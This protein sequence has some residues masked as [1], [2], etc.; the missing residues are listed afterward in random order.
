MSAKLASEVVYSNNLT[1]TLFDLGTETHKHA[2]ENQSLNE[3]AQ[4]ERFIKHLGTDNV[5]VDYNHN[6]SKLSLNGL[7]VKAMIMVMEWVLTKILIITIS[8]L[9]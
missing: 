1:K 8:F 6:E 4:N 7:M 5:W 9:E 2:I 3:V